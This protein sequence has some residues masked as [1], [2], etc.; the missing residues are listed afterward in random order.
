MKYSLKLPLTMEKGEWARKMRKSDEF[1]L[2]ESISTL[3]MHN[4]F[5]G[6]RRQYL[7][8]RWFLNNWLPLFHFFPWLN[9]DFKNRS[10]ILN[11]VLCV[12]FGQKN[13]WIRATRR[14]VKQ[15]S[16]ADWIYGKMSIVGSVKSITSSE[17]NKILMTDVCFFIQNK[18]KSFSV[19][20]GIKKV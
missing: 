8:L 16:I 13:H 17:I 10:I 2:Q 3:L 4:Q 6:Y 12:F 20:F 7:C 9:V 5:F 14:N 1:S 19:L 11:H 15:I 18:L